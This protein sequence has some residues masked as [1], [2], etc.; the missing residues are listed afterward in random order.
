MASIF[1]VREK[2]IYHGDTESRRATKV[3]ERGKSADSQL[4]FWLYFSNVFS[5]PSVSSVLN[6]I[7]YLLLCR[8]RPLLIPPSQQ[9]LSITLRVPL[10][11]QHRKSV[12]EGSQ[13]LLPVAL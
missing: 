11:A 8:I 1:I 6:R 3:K 13:K 7:C 4:S 2:P 5:V 10:V 9:K 12:R